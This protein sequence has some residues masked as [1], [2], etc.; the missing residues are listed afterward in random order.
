M[1]RLPALRATSRGAIHALSHPALLGEFHRL[2]RRAG[3]DRAARSHARARRLTGPA[4]PYEILDLHRNVDL[5]GHHRLPCFSVPEAETVTL[6]NSR[7][8]DIC[9]QTPALPR[10]NRQIR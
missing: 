1:R 2:Y 9:R 7:G 6:G 5:G 4:C 10:I 8:T 3:A